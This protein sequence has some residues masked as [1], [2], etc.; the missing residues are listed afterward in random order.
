M[1]CRPIKRRF[2]G[3]VGHADS[4]AHQLHFVTGEILREHLACSQIHGGQPV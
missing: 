1:I 3:N 2:I 4:E